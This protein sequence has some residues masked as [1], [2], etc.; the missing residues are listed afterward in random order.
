MSNKQNDIFSEEL[1]EALEEVKALEFTLSND[2]KSLT[3]ALEW[4]YRDEKQLATA[5]LNLQR[6]QD[7]QF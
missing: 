2:R 3:D 1:Q 4:V 5:K 7:K 6:L